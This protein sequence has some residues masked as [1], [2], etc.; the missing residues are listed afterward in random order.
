MLKKF[1]FSNS[2]SFQNEVALDLSAELNQ[3][4][5]DE[6]GNPMPV[7]SELHNI[8][9]NRIVEGRWGVLPVAAIYGKN[10]SGKTR[11][12]KTLQ[13][14]AKDALGDSFASATAFSS[15]TPYEQMI[16]RRRYEN[17][18]K[19][20]T[21]IRYFV[22]VVRGDME[23]SLEYEL[24]SEGITFEEVKQRSLDSCTEE[25]LL[26]SRSLNELEL[27][28]DERVGRLCE[29]LKDSDVKSLWFP[30]VAQSDVKLRKFYEWFRYVRDGITFNNVARNPNR[31]NELGKRIAGENDE[32]FKKKLL[33]FLRCLD[34]SITDIEGQVVKDGSYTLWLY[35]RRHSTE[36]DAVADLIR[37]ESEGTLKLLEQFPK[38]DKVLEQGMPFIC[39]ELDRSLHPIAFKQ[40]VR[41][42]NCPQ[43]NNKNAQLIFTAH[44]TFVLD[45][46][47]LRRDEVHIIDK[48]EH[49]VSTIT[50]LSDRN[51]VE[52]YPNM[53]YDFRTGVYGSFPKNMVDS[54]VSVEE[55]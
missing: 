10:A 15:L 35:H 53:E 25:Q 19:K 9:R 4:L 52:P 43:I 49:S 16:E 28:A 36:Y 51:D 32:P 8:V 30:S 11:L 37:D 13:D 38:I 17:A 48:D 24:S 2:Y 26:Y 18:E 50:R 54:Y 7:D 27:G 23:Y 45:S 5:L 6:N 22:C 41:M 31:W 29:M 47:F 42:F 44:D 1:K 34:S 39:D 14:V 20:F 12:L 40:I 21:P 46:D 55:A 33:N 3:G